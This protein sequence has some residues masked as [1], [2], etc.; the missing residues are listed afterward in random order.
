MD[1]LLIVNEDGR[2][3]CSFSSLRR[4][5]VTKEDFFDVKLSKFDGQTICMFGIFDCRGGYCAAEYLKKHLFEN[6]MKHPLF[7]TDTKI[8]ISV[9]KFLTQC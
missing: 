6:L 3:S 4:R 1:F 2:L 8:V 9:F 5:Q 7:I